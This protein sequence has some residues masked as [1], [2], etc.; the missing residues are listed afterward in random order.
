MPYMLELDVDSYGFLVGGDDRLQVSPA[1]HSWWHPYPHIPD[2][3][4]VSW[5]PGAL[6]VRPNIYAH[7]LLRDF[8]ADS[9]AFDVLARVIDN[10]FHVY[11]KMMLDGN[12]LS[13]IQAAETLDVVDESLSL[14]SEFRRDEIAFPHIPEE[15]D[16]AT[17]NKIFRVPNRGL[18]LSVF[19]GEG[20]KQAYDEAGLTGWLFHSTRV[21]P[22]EWVLSVSRCEP[23]SHR[24]GYYGKPVWPGRRRSS[25]GEIEEIR[26]ERTV[27]DC[28]SRRGGRA[29]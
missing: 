6:T 28:L 12:E 16:T 9:V 18:S 5:E 26:P 22:D 27:G 2:R 8:V 29:G 20:V 25:F 3:L 24:R 7:N 17:M 4:A 19:V 10:G 15:N 11:G 13:V 14:T 23:Y 21:Q 1:L